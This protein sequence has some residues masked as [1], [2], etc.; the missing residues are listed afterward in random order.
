MANRF[1]FIQQQ[2]P[3]FVFVDIIGIALLWYLVGIAVD[4]LRS[5]MFMKAKK[6]IF[7]RFFDKIDSF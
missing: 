5:S 6:G 3:F 1:A 2:N 7:Q 4:F